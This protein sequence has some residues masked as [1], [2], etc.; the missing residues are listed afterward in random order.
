M[1]IKDRLASILYPPNATRLEPKVSCALILILSFGYHDKDTGYYAGIIASSLFVGR[2][3]G[4][5]FWGYLTDKIGRKP[6][7]LLSASLTYCATLFFGFSTNLYFAVISRFLQGL[8][9]GVIVCGRAAFSE[10]CDDTNQ[11]IGVSLIF[12]AWNS[13]IVLGPALGG[14]LAHPTAK[15]P[16]LFG[17]GATWRFFH[18]FKY[19][20]P[21]VLI[22]TL[23]LF[24]II[25]V[26]FFFE[27]TLVSK[28]QKVEEGEE[29]EDEYTKD[30]ERLLQKDNSD[31]DHEKKNKLLVN[32]EVGGIEKEEGTDEHNEDV[33]TCSCARKLSKNITETSLW[34]L[35]R[36]KLVSLCVGMFGLSGFIIIGFQEVTAVWMASGVKLGGLA[37]TTDK[38][39]LALLFPALMS[40][41]I[42]P[43]IFGRLERKLGGIKTLRFFLIFLALMTIGFPFI[44]A[45]HKSRR[46][47]WSLLIIMRFFRMI[48][49]ISVRS[50]LAMFV[51]NSVSSDKAGIVNGYAFSVQEI[52]R[53]FSPSLLGALFAWSVRYGRKIGFPLDHH[54]AFFVLGVMIT[55][56]I[57]LSIFLPESINLPKRMS[58][59]SSAASSVKSSP[60]MSRTA[61]PKKPL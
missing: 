1:A 10:I 23:L 54:I 40:V 57:V 6:V 61:L 20:L 53:V 32:A 51:N 43:L 29:E 25:A 13:A 9:N 52:M 5:Y 48:S 27:E 12:A 37:F 24:S 28:K 45:A 55:L 35:V 47:I 18:K 34:A 44:S 41:I 11:A 30:T 14:F 50:A 56:L 39:G 59:A 2:F 26:Y 46:A 38:I 15:Y 60:A 58:A 22:S 42:Q 33:V 7:L 4:G 16:K 21:S 31:E 8:C 49:D 19:L 3:F 17:H 36:D